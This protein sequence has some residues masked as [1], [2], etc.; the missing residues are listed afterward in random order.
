MPA[1]D[2]NRRE[3][4]NTTE[5]LTNL[6]R[7]PTCMRQISQHH[8]LNNVIEEDNHNLAAELVDSNEALGGSLFIFY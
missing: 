1:V 4:W 5:R 6:E 3:W 7:P 8:L 2:V